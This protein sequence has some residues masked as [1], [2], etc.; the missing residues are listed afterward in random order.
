MVYN[1]NTQGLRVIFRSLF[2]ETKLSLT[3]CSMMVHG[4]SLE[5]KGEGNRLGPGNDILH[6]S[7]HTLTSWAVVGSRVQSLTV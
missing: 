4:R 6:S 7:L 5:V 2:E 1:G 3:L